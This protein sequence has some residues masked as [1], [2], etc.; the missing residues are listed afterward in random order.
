MTDQV[1]DQ[2]KYLCHTPKLLLPSVLDNGVVLSVGSMNRCGSVKCRSAG[3]GIAA[4]RASLGQ[5]ATVA[6]PACAPRPALA[7]EAGARDA[8][9]GCAA[10][11]PARQA[12]CAAAAVEAVE[13][14]VQGPPLTDNAYPIPDK[15]QR[16]GPRV[17][18]TGGG[19]GGLVLAVGLLKKGF[20][21]HVFERDLTAIR[22]E[23]KY[24]GPIQ[25]RRCAC[26]V[27]TRER[28]QQGTTRMELA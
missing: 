21:V 2:A 22:G 9:G 23:G 3:S 10:A 14:A 1:E 18:I 25:V 17:L 24:R 27:C 11:R 12:A 6:S 4:R 28:G 19:I 8:R 7:G 13:A 15:A 26:L 16:T 20:D 5:A